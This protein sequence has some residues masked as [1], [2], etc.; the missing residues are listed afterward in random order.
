M[1]I[2]EEFLH[3]QKPISIFES[4]LQQKE[5]TLNLD[6]D[7]SISYTESKDIET[8][9]KIKN[10]LINAETN[11]NINFSIIKNQ[12]EE[13]DN[14]NDIAYEN[15]I[16]AIK[17]KEIYIGGISPNFQMREGFGLNKYN[18]EDSFYLGKWSNNMKEGLGCLKIDTNNIYIG[19]FHQN[20]F[21]GE[22]ILNI[23]SENKNILFFGQMS[24]SEFNEGIYID[25]DKELYYIGKFNNGK[26]NDDFCIMIEKNNRQIFVGKVNDDIFEHGYL[27]L[28][29][30]EEIQGQDENGEDISGVG[31]GVEKIFYY[32]KDQDG[33][34][35][36]I[37]EFENTEI[38]SQ[39]MEKIVAFEYEITKQIEN[40]MNYFSYL[41]ALVNDDDFNSLLRYNDKDDK[42]LSYLFVNNYNFHLEKYQEIKENFDIN[43]IKNK[44]DISSQIF[45]NEN[46]NE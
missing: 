11:K 41:N 29:N 17:Y 31:F 27:C 13:N 2:E 8:T 1:I 34:N 9:T 14:D 35:Q 40:T 15:N 22:G 24:N 18:D 23:S 39:N 7:I 32:Y 12:K 21:D 33:K 25:I 26:K 6:K 4:L 30:S 3:E 19:N 46:E 43:E 42:S 37:Y 28:Y 5:P 36:F 44:I 16:F 38:L 10:I 20:Q 45:Q